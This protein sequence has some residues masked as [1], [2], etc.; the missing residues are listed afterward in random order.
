MFLLRS[1]KLAHLANVVVLLPPGAWRSC[2]QGSS[3][4]K[5]CFPELPRLWWEGRGGGFQE[6]THSLPIRPAFLGSVELSGLS[7]RSVI[8]FLLPL[9]R[10]AWTQRL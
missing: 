1:E 7:R 5:H 8:Q 9:D 10:G 6:G 2:Q 3:T 4:Q